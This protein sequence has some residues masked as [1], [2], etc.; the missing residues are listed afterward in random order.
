VHLREAI[1]LDLE[2]DPTGGVA[3]DE[4]DEVPWDATGTETG[5]DDIDRGRRKAFKEA[6]D[7]ATH[8]YFHFRDAE[9][10]SG[11]ILFAVL[12]DEVDVV[13]A[14]NLVAVHVDDLLVE[15]VALEQEIAFILR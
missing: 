3:V 7:S 6:A 1:L 5:G 15:Q 10:E 11:A 4:V 13:D 9:R 2:T 14:D 12:P 8:S